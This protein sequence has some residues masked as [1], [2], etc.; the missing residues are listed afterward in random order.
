[1]L[2]IQMV[3]ALILFA[4][5]AQ[6]PARDVAVEQSAV[7]YA[8][9]EF[10]QA[11]AEHKADVEQMERTRKALEPLQKQFEQEQKKA[12]LSEQKQRQAQARLHKAEEALERAWKQ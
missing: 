2:K 10:R 8:R 3:A 7:E 12:G 6:V 4:A 5:A 1:M 11:E 9:R